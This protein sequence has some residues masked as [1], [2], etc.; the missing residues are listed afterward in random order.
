MHEQML[1]MSVC[2]QGCECVQEPVLV[3]VH[4]RLK[5]NEHAYMHNYTVISSTRIQAEYAVAQG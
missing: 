4:V 5:G 1:H 3:G 2:V